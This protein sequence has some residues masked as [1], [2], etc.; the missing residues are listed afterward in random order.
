MLVIIDQNALYL[1]VYLAILLIPR[2]SEAFN[3]SND[4]NSYANSYIN[5]LSI[6]T[7][8]LNPSFDALD[9]DI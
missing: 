2:G 7:P 4:Q 9:E 1:E 3:Q 8:S 6:P 5:N